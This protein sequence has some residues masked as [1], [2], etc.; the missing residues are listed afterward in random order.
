MPGLAPINSVFQTLPGTLTANR[1]ASM[2]QI[3]ANTTGSFT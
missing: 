1:A 2:H 3:Y